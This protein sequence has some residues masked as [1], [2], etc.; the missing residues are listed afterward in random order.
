MAMA[1]NKLVGLVF[2]AWNDLDRV[3]E[4]VSADDAVRQIAG[5]S[6]FAWTL[7]HVT[8]QL[9]SWINV[10]FQ[11]RSPHPLIG[12][13]RF[14]RGAS[15]EADDWDGI[16]LGVYEVREVARKYLRN[17][18]ESDLD[19]VIPYS[20]SLEG[21][22]E[23]GLSLRYALMRIAAHHYFHIGVIA[24]QRDRLGYQVGDYPGSLAECL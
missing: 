3:L 9:D 2:E 1:H 15:G 19:L 23:H 24:C 8:Q 20:G 12:F 18:T 17:L 5:Q 21:L 11:G 22:R 13:D 10:N 14:R 6:S 16:R 4:G 7:A